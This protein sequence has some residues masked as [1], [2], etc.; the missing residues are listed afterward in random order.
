MVTRVCMCVSI[1]K[2]GGGKWLIPKLN[3]AGCIAHLGSQRSVPGAEA[4]V[5]ISSQSNALTRSAV[6]D[7]TITS[8]VLV[9]VPVTTTMAQVFKKDFKA[10]KNASVLVVALTKD[11]AN[12][13]KQHG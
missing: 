8:P 11:S 2:L 3:A 9:L 1:L 12:G 4:Y 10:F 7:G 6:I 5:C 13:N